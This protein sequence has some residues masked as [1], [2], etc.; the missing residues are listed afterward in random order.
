LSK[1]AMKKKE[2][3]LGEWICMN[4]IIKNYVKKDQKHK[5]SVSCNQTL[6]QILPFLGVHLNNGNIYCTVRTLHGSLYVNEKTPK[7]WCGK[8]FM[9]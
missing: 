8:D 2:K 5:K 7:I 4:V 1:E 3:G 9:T 6:L